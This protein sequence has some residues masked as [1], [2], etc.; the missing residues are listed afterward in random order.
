MQQAPID[1]ARS[2]LLHKC[3]I[4]CG[5]VQ[6]ICSWHH[7][8]DVPRWGLIVS[9]QCRLL[10]QHNP[11]KSL[12]QLYCTERTGSQLLQRVCCC[13]TTQLARTCWQLSELAAGCCR[14]R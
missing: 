13:T 2:S 5:L 3:T 10:G 14:V 9:Q 7:A 6:C 12:Q 1:Y 4:C 8:T 11:C